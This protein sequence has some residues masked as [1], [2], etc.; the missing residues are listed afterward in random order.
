LEVSNKSNISMCVSIPALS[1]RPVVAMTDQAVFNDLLLPVRPIGHIP[2]PPRGR[3][4]V[5][6]LPASVKPHPELLATP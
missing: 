6:L 1:K 4:G 2:L 3:P 5:L